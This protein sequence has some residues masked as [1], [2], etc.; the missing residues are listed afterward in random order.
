MGVSWCDSVGRKVTQRGQMSASHDHRPSTCVSAASVSGSQQV[1]SVA[2]YRSTAVESSSRGIGKSFCWI[3][4]YDS[5]YHGL[6][7][8][9]TWLWTNP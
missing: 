5:R 4:A 1:I 2:S 7:D 3:S 9:Q 6:K 8:R